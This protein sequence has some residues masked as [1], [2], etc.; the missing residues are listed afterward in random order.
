MGNLL[1]VN[2]PIGRRSGKYITLCSLRETIKYS[3]Q[4]STV[5][6]TVLTFSCANSMAYQTRRFNAAFPRALQKYLS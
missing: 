6:Y 4:H 2:V 5:L 3:L 1:D